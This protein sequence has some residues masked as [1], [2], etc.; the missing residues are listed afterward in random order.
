MLAR[1]T[2]GLGTI[3]RLDTQGASVS[4]PSAYPSRSRIIAG[5]IARAEAYPLEASVR[6]PSGIAEGG[7][8]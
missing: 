8:L 6:G 7:E 3:G 5:E 2:R 4:E 1:P